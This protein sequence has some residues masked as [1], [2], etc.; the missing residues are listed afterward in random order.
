MPAWLIVLLCLA[1]LA[2]GGLIAY[3]LLMWYL[4][5]AFRG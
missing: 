1:C 4:S 3:V 5:K 2:A